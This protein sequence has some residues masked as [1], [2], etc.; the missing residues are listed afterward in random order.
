MVDT[1][2]LKIGYS[3]GRT[4]QRT[5]GGGVH[6]VGRESGEIVLGDPNV[7]GTHLELRVANGEVFLTDVGSSNGTFD[8]TGAR[9]HGSVRMSPNQPYRLGGSSLTWIA[10][11]PG[12]APSAGGTAVMP[13]YGAPPPHAGAGPAPM[14]S[15]QQGY[16]PPQHGY[17]PPHT[18]APYAPPQSAWTPPPGT[19]GYGGAY[20]GAPMA[21][22]YG[23]PPEAR[24]FGMLCHI[25]ALAGYIVPF[26]HVLGPLVFWMMKKDT[27]PFVD[28]QGKE[29][30]NFQITVTIA[31]AVF[32]GLSF[33][34]IG[35]P[36]L[37]AT[38]VASLIFEILAGM[39]ANAG[40]S[41][42]YPFTLRLL[43]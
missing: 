4:E 29:S 19:P 28:E 17:A 31:Y 18:G 27:H 24:T 2:Q 11:S 10:T 30:L 12:V 43:T 8:A 39:K 16:A 22:P 38:G 14:P 5:L 20:P 6:K 32:G 41:Y 21:G 36:F 42:R 9:V 33:F 35:I 26:G 15:P 7:S 13:Q 1:A 34:L 23:V 3:D 40:I 37:V 25:G